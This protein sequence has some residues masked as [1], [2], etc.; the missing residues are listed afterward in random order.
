M[1]SFLQFSAGHLVYK[2]LCIFGHPEITSSGKI[3]LEQWGHLSENEIE[4]FS[5]KCGFLIDFIESSSF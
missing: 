2:F 1:N 4:N 5:R 3:G